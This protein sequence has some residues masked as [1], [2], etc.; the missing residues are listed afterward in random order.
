MTI[1]EPS[2]EESILGPDKQLLVD[3][4]PMTVRDDMD[5]SERVLKLE[6]RK[7]MILSMGDDE[8]QK[9]ARTLR[10]FRVAVDVKIQGDPAPKVLGQI[11]TKFEES[12]SKGGAIRLSNVR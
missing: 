9:L 1:G 12:K 10:D 11:F 7:T 6:E 2:R 4:V 3:L 8:A 5:A